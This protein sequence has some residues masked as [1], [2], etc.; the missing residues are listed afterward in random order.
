[1]GTVV[2]SKIAATPT[3]TAWSQ[4]Y[5]AGKLFTVLSLKEDSAKNL[6]EGE[7]PPSGGSLKAIGKNILDTLE[8]EFF[9]LEEKNL[10]SI[11]GAVG[12]ALKGIPQEAQFSFITAVVSENIL[13]SCIVGKGEVFIKRGDKFGYVLQSESDSKEISSASGF[14][15]NRDLIILATEGFTKTVSKEHLSESLD[16]LPPAEIAENLAPKVH[17][18]DEAGA[19]AIILSYKEEAEAHDAVAEEEG[20]EINTISQDADIEKTNEE[21]ESKKINPIGFIFPLFAGVKNLIP[22]RLSHSKKVYL[23]IVALVLLVLVASVLLGIKKQ[24]DAK[25]ESAFNSIYPQAQKNFDEGESLKDLNT[26]LAID[27]FN[28]AKKILEENIDK[29]PKNSKQAKQ[30]ND[31]LSKVNK[32]IKDISPSAG[33]KNLDRSKITISVQNGSG[34]EGAAGTASDFLEEKGYKVSSKANADNYN[35]EGSTIKVKKTIENYLDMLKKDLGEKYKV[36]TASSDLSSGS[37]TDAVVIIG[38]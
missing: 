30:V 20:A 19:A 27:S 26:S 32:E 34:V 3:E 8:T 25:I 13:Y 31:L 14:L 5:S 1:M 9:S 28:Q 4:A 23:T 16:H 12:Q 33:T 18:G 38:K 15:E 10:E 17:E 21:L 29:F 36:S 6:P 24:N 37:P 11:K 35:Y 22:A 2:F 7:N